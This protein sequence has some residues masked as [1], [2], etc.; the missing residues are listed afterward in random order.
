MHKQQEPSVQFQW[1]C[2]EY[3]GDASYTVTRAQQ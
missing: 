1:V 3:F 2:Q